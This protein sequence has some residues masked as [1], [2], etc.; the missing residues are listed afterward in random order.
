MTRFTRSNLAASVLVS[1]AVIAT[2]ADFAQALQTRGPSNSVTPAAPTNGNTP[3]GPSDSI[4]SGCQPGTTFRMCPTRYYQPQP[5]AEAC[6]RGLWEDNK[7][8]YILQQAHVCMHH[9]LTPIRM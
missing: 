3:T 7:I 2:T 5:A 1:L 4:I 6:A 8:G 9:R